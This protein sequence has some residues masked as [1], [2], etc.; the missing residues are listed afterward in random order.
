[1]KFLIGAQLPS[2][3][4]QLFT[5]S[6]YD[7][8]HTLDL[9]LGNDTSDAVIKEISVAER[10]ILIIKDNDFL[11]SFIVKNQPYKLIMVRLGNT[12]KRE[13]IQFFKSRFA[14]IIDKIETENM[15]SKED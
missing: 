15:L 5:N 14:E 3:L 7:C 6:G 1:M 2:S 13:L 8:I 11:H 9:E 12:S 10:R 4:K